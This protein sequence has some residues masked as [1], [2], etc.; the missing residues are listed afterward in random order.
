MVS[1][2]TDR[3]DGAQFSQAIKSPC[4]VISTSNLTLSGEQ[5]V[6]SVAVVEGDRALVN[7]QTDQTENG[8]WVVETGAWVRAPD[9]DGARDIVDGTLVTVKKTTG[10]NFFYQLDGTN[11]ILIGTSNIVFLAANDPNVSWP[12]TQAEIDDGLTTSN[13]TDSYEPGNPRRNGAVFD[14]VTDDSTALQACLN[15]NSQVDISGGTLDMEAGTFVTVPANTTI[16]GDSTVIGGFTLTGD[17]I[18]IKD[19]TIKQATGLDSTALVAGIEALFNGAGGAVSHLHIEGV[20]FDTCSLNVTNDDATVDINFVF[21]RNRWIGDVAADVIATSVTFGNLNDFVLRGNRFEQTNLLGV[22]KQTSTGYAASPA[23]VDDNYNRREIIDGNFFL[24]SIAANVATTEVIDFYSSATELV[25][26]NNILNTTGADTVI[27]TK[28]GGVTDTIQ[29]RDILIA[30]NIVNTDCESTVF[31]LQGAR[32]Q[33][34]EGTAQNIVV[35]DNIINASF[36]TITRAISVRDYNRAVISDNDINYTGTSTA[37]FAIAIRGVEHTTITGGDIINSIIVLSET[38]SDPHIQ[39][40]NING[41]SIIDHQ[42]SAILISGID[43]GGYLNINGCTMISGGAEAPIEFD[44]NSDITLAHI[45]G[46][47]SDGLGVVYISTTFGDLSDTNNSWDQLPQALVGAGAVNITSKITHVDTTGGAAAL[48]LI[49]GYDRQEK[50]L[51]MKTDGGVGTLTPD[52]LGNGST[53]VFD[54][55]GD[56]AHLIFTNAAWHMIGGTATLA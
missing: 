22:I 19:I 25:F 49:D 54:D 45:S 17:G 41:V 40:V 46:N 15:S 34:F 52:S 6:N 23:T 31:S 14:G 13:I 10:M 2:F 38:G 44:T 27:L 7:G 30:N 32:G 3:F 48:T 9:F 12:I 50:F 24:G 42:D 43:G 11:P 8:I 5:T 35:S 1:A 53:I 28:A 18:T 33:S 55:V 36:N 29:H 4:V 20:T 16:T 51:V 47:V 39:S 21:L 56:S 26:T 37:F